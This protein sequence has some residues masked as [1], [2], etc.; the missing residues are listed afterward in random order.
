MELK[1]EADSIGQTIGMS[2][3]P[4]NSLS[5]DI[6]IVLTGAMKIAV[7][8][9]IWMASA[10]HQTIERLPMFIAILTIIVFGAIILIS[11]RRLLRKWVIV[12]A[13]FYVVCVVLVFAAAFGERCLG[14]GTPQ[15]ANPVSNQ[16][17]ARRIQN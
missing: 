14:L 5:R 11:G 3:L 4:S 2:S 17:G 6:F 1:E 8:W 9:A 12:F 13:G 7:H 10:T 15:E 16:A